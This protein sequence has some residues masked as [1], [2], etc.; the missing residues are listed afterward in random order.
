MF[1]CG[2]RLHIYI[3]IFK[4]ST[5]KNDGEK[6]FCGGTHSNLVAVLLSDGRW[7]QD[8]GLGTTARHRAVVGDRQVHAPCKALSLQQGLLCVSRIT[9]RP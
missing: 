2:D 6:P 8:E 4:K 1:P 5:L 9:W 7:S 3:C